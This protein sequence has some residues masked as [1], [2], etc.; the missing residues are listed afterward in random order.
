ME[1]GGG[2]MD[3]LCQ[4]LIGIGWSDMG[5]YFASLKYSAA[6]SGG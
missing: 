6:S 5:N 3:D 4:K 2:E 1:E